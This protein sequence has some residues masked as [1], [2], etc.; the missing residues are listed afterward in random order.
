VKIFIADVS[1]DKEVPAEF[2][3]LSGSGVRIWIRYG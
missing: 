3:N 2:R 1:L